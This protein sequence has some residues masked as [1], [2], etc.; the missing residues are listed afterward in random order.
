MYRG[1]VV[2][3]ALLGIVCSHST[4]TEPERP[5]LFPFVMPWDDAT[6]GVT[7][8]SGWLAKPAGKL[9][10]VHA[11]EGH[12]Y[13]GR[14]CIR[15]FGVNLCF[16]AD[17]PRKEDAPKI[18]A[19]MAK[20]G[21]NVVRFHHMDS[22]TFPGGIRARKVP[23]TRD[24]DPEALDRL[25]FFVAQL[26]SQGI[27][28]NLNLL[29]S[30]PF[31]AADGL[32]AE[33]E[34]V[35]W[36]ERHA[37]GF[38]F[39]P[40]L[41]LQKEYARKLLTHRNPYT[42]STYA[43]EPAVAFV[44]I[45]NENGL[46]HA[47]LGNDL[48]KLP[49]VFLKDLQRQWNAW[50]RQR[51]ATTEN[52]RKAWKVKDEAPGAELLVNGN[53]ADGAKR[54]TLERHEKAEATAV[55]DDEAPPAVR[56]A[57]R[58]TKA[59]R[60]T[61]TRSSSAAWHVQFNQPGLNVHASRPYTLSFWAR[62]DKP[63][64]FRANLSQAHAPWQALGLNTPVRVTSEWK[65]FRF[66]FEPTQDDANA[67]IVFSDLARQAAAV[68]LAG[69]SFRPGGAVGLNPG[70]RVEDGSL[71][72]F[73]HARF[74]ER[75][76]EGQR[77]W[78]RFLWETEDA[79]WQEMQRYLKED[80]HV[81]GVVMGTIVGCSTPN[82]M[83]R[84]GAVDSHAYW[85]HPQFPGR[86][87]DPENWT[88]QNRSMVNEVGGTLPGLALRRVVGKP[89]CVTEYNHAA[90]NT[91]G[92]EGFLLLA[93][94]GALQDWDAVYAFAYSHRG[95]DWNSQKISG[96]FDIDQHPTRMVTLPPAVAMFVRRDV[97]PAHKQV[98]AALD[99]EREVDMLRSS[100][101]WNLVHAEHAGVPREI[102]LSHR[103]AIATEGS[104]RPD[105]PAPDAKPANQARLEADTGELSWD[106]HTKG[107][108]VVTVNT[109]KSKAVIGYGGGRRFDLGG[110]A[111]EPGAT[112]QDG[113]SAITLTA[114]DGDFSTKACK[115]LI[116]ATGYAENTDMVW[117][118]EKT[119]V[120]RNWGKAPSLVEGVQV[121]ITLP[122]RA[123]KV[124]SWSL[125]ECGHRKE[126]L[127]IQTGTD[128]SAVLVLGAAARTLWYEVDCQP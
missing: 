43:E 116:T 86:P 82:L 79:Y 62:S 71:P 60:L 74:G 73:P 92:S 27:Y 12:F 124:K 7:N 93:A 105:M 15:F 5:Q 56:A 75:T 118:T 45:N 48:D 80:L 44:E 97:R 3:V 33:I 23:H 50:L 1:I 34:H 66:V 24:L 49:D 47:W 99:K 128:G 76:A 106:L 29:V 20:F 51:H 100:R 108:G 120:G 10:P 126:R 31:N 70:E 65:Q 41:A 64:E 36:K 59:I 53:F 58:T 55:S 38:F 111:I 85:Q 117:N 19:R 4:A 102:A 110:V 89:H 14:E 13:T 21:I 113:W 115:L 109:P 112:M 69:V 122:Q 30:R 125:D 104:R 57:S 6:P 98:V 72:V 61:V 32:P 11:A 88:I 28:A 119:S 91:F 52:L 17:F 87:W 96:F 2:S 101:A 127:T 90:P 68:S 46:I 63:L 83:A 107:R 67:R 37:A 42:E 95:N 77:D 78:V 22:G 16:G 40:A 54:W 94:Y 26:K 103:I 8:L 114:M 84:L 35:G 123:G 121:R 25:D 39:D 81:K 9:G 18:A